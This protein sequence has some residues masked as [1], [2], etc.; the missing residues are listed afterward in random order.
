MGSGWEREGLEMGEVGG[1]G[2]GW[3]VQWVGGGKSNE[4]KITHSHYLL[5]KALRHWYKSVFGSY[6]PLHVRKY[7][8]NAA[9][10]V[11]TWLCILDNIH[12]TLYRYIL[13]YI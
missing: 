5:K 4:K 10:S 6:P 7:V 8:C 13:T 12:M 1:V 2:N 9:T 3:K 11:C